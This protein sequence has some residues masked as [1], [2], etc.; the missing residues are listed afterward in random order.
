VIADLQYVSAIFLP[1]DSPAEMAR[2]YTEKFGI[3]MPN[4]WE[5]GF[6]GRLPQGTVSFMLGV[7]PRKD[8]QSRWEGLSIFF[9]VDDFAGYL[10]QLREKDL[11]PYEVEHTHNGHFASFRD[12][13]GYTVVVWHPNGDAR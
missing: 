10:E 4:E 2:W 11:A 3:A 8:G 12:P 1:A 5:G 13:E 7:V 6:Y 9:A